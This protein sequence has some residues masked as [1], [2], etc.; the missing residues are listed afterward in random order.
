MKKKWVSLLC[1]GLMLG[2]TIAI[3]AENMPGESQTILESLQEST[4]AI[5]EIEEEIAR[6]MEGSAAYEEENDEA[7]NEEN[8]TNDETSASE[9]SEE[10]VLE[11][12]VPVVQASESANRSGSHAGN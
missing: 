2:S 7:L 5:Y 11:D 3:P 12:K 9:I 6:P 8:F 1:A 4:E 10:E